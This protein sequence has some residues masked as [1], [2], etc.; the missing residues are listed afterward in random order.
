MVGRIGAIVGL[1]GL[2]LMPAMA[3]ADEAIEFSGVVLVQG[4]NPELREFS[5]WLGARAGYPLKPAYADSYQVVSNRLREHKR[6]L[7]WTCGAPYVEDRVTDGQILVAVPLFKGKPTYH[8]VTITRRG[9]KEKD[10]ADF[11]GQVLAY[12]DPRSNSG[13]VVPAF[14]LQ[15]EGLDINWHFRLLLHTGLHEA[16][17]RAVLA[18]LADVANVDEYVLVEYLKNHPEAK[19][20]IAILKSY[21]PYPFTPIVAGSQTP[22]E[23]V[24]R[25]RKALVGMA[26]D[27]QGREILRKL[28]LDGFVVK[29]PKF[30][31]P[32]AHM[33]E[34][35][36]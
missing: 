19:E 7:A 27:A 9:R 35:L 1:L 30:F 32:I 24:A 17:I 8:S 12:S 11:A 13:F 26:E 22:P 6:Y 16:S 25:L 3:L 20:K 28:G 21:G 23:A 29:P 14:E 18:G 4:D 2:L 33:L 5:K 31:D 36:K 10:L 34:S 15:K